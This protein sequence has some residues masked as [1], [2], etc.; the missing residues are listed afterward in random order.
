MP[1]VL[2][3][4]DDLSIA[5]LLQEQLEADGYSVTGVARSLAEAVTSA[6]EHQPDFAVIDLHLAG[7]DLGTDVALR[8]REITSVGIIFS[9]GNNDQDLTA[10]DGDAVMSKP[11]RM[12]DVGRGLKI[13]DE[14]SH[15]GH[16]ELS[17]PRNF[18]FIFPAPALV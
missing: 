17:Y 1:H 13:I 10:F 4:E 11:Y 7:G 3:V 18:H 12:S 6:K 15:T 5:F 14:M 2:I 16:T 8:L 9:T